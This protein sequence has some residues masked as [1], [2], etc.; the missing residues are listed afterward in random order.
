MI[1][2]GL[3]GLGALRSLADSL[4]ASAYMAVPS[5]LGVGKSF[6]TTWEHRRHFPWAR[7]IK[8]LSCMRLYGFLGIL[9]LCFSLSTGPYHE[10]TL[11]SDR[12]KLM[13]MTF[14]A[15]VLEPCDVVAWLCWDH[16]PWAFCICLRCAVFCWIAWLA[17][18]QMHSVAWRTPV[19]QSL[20]IQF[21]RL[22]HFAA[23]LDHKQQ[24]KDKIWSRRL[25]SALHSCLHSFRS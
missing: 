8:S 15:L 14:L 21:L 6:A 13:T 20:D 25:K 11:R 18:H 4:Q 9:A 2:K 17:S 5:R 3:W 22:L 24:I 7:Y 19:Q 16:L 12:R 23:Q 1:F 10:S